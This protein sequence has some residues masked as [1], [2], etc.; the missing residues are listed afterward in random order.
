MKDLPKWF[1][2]TEDGSLHGYYTLDVLL[3]HLTEHRGENFEILE[4]KKGWS[5]RY[6]P[7]TEETL[8]REGKS[9]GQFAIDNAK[10]LRKV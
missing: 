7:I 2:R 5:V 1:V 6:S 10:E 3:C 4:L 9:L 8:R